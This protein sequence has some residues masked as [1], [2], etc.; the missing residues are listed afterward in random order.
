MSELVLGTVQFGLNYGITNSA[1]EI[2]DSEMA[3]MLNLATDRGINLFDTAADYGNSQHRL[4]TVTQNNQGRKYVTKFSLPADGSKPT[5][6]NIFQDSLKQLKVE[7]LHG[8]LFHKLENLADFR[9]QSTIEILRAGRESGQVERIGVSIYN[10]EDL[11]KACEVFPDF[12]IIQLPANILDLELLESI[13]LLELKER[14][15]EVHVRSVFLQGLLL[16]NP[17]TLPEYFELLTPALVELRKVAE[18]TGKSVLELVL[19]KMRN[20]PVIDA[21]LVGATS[22]GELDEVTTAWIAS[23]EAE[24]FDLP[25]VPRELL[26]PRGWPQIRMNP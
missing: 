14:G 5:P 21:V 11:S 2:S 25:E 3:A 18:N 26:D 13:P 8:V 10:S 7:Q 16:S 6:A 23:K 9:T 12:D 1:G 17:D 20:H 19:G 4:G 15:V 24:E 22:A